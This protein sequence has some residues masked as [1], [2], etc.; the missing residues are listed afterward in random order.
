MFF[1]C[2]L[3]NLQSYI[4]KVAALREPELGYP[5]MEAA[6]KFPAYDW[7]SCTNG[8]KSTLSKPPRASSILCSILKDLTIYI[9]ANVNFKV[10]LQNR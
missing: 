9:L 6:L 8:P 2:P 1:D 3:L 10:V 7:L 4:S 5:V